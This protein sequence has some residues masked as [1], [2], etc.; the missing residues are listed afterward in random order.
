MTV[1]SSTDL[2]KTQI[3]T[4]A[5]RAA[6]KGKL[7][8][9]DSVFVSSGAIRVFG[10]MPK[11]GRRAIGTTIEVPYWAALGDFERLTESQST[12]PQKVAMT[13]ETA[14][15]VRDSI[16]FETSAWAV[17]TADAEGFD[18]PITVLSQEAAKSAKRCMDKAMIT[19]GSSSPLLTSIYNATTPKYLTWQEVLKAM[20]I[21][22]GDDSPAL[23]GWP[24]THWSPLTCRC[25]LT[26]LDASTWQIRARISW[27]DASLAFRSSSP[28]EYRL[29]G[30]RCRRWLAHT[31][32]LAGPALAVALPPTRSR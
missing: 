23:S 8:L 30:R 1:T 14:T 24:A 27:L 17:G 6:L 26:R 2:V 12:T 21:K 9:M 18:D 3:M 10:T 11:R 19:A 31:P 13:Y 16:S 15:V 25:K 20:S 29:P 5:V 22:M 32:Q 7:G 28:T 4:D